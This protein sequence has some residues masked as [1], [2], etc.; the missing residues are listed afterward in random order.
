MPDLAGRDFTEMQMGREPRGTGSAGAVA[1]FVI[2]RHGGAEKAP[3]L[4][5]CPGS[6]WL[7]R[8]AYGFGPLDFRLQF[9]RVE[10]EGFRPVLRRGD[11]PRRGYGFAGS[12][13][14]ETVSP[15]GRKHLERFAALIL[16]LPRLLEQRAIETL[17]L[18]AAGK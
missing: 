6:A 17:G 8:G 2:I 13:I 4:R 15:E 11:I 16:N 10:R 1:V 5:L 18:Q 14:C 3:Q 12:G 9:Q 7:P